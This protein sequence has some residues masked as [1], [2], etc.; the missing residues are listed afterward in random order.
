MFLLCD[1][2]KINNKKYS[3]LNLY[4]IQKRNKITIYLVYTQT[5]KSLRQ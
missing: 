4:K 1:K 3:N 5:H 2:N